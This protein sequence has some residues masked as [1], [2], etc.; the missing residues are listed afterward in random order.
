[1]FRNNKVLR[2]DPIEINDLVLTRSDTFYF[3]EFA[4]YT[5]DLFD[6]LRI[7]S[8]PSLIFY[9]E[10]SVNHVVLDY[11]LSS[12]EDKMFIEAFFANMGVE[13]EFTLTNGS[14]L[15]DT[16]NIEAD[17]SSTLKFKKIT[18]SLIFAEVVSTTDK[19]STVDQYLADFFIGTPQLNK[20]GNLE[21]S[22]RT[23]IQALVS[24][25]P[26]NTAK[27]IL[28]MG[29][30]P[31][32]VIEILC[33]SSV[34][35]NKKFTII[36]AGIINDK[37]VLYLETTSIVSESLIGKAAIINLYQRSNIEISDVNQIAT[38]QTTLG[39]CNDAG[40]N[41]TLPYH[42]QKQ[43]LLRGVPFVWK[44]GSCSDTTTNLTSSVS[45]ATSLLPQQTDVAQEVFDKNIL[46]LKNSV[47]DPQYDQL[48]SFFKKKI[49]DNPDSLFNQNPFSEYFSATDP[50][51][52]VDPFEMFFD[53]NVVRYSVPVVIDSNIQLKA[54][55]AVL[56]GA[57]F[58]TVPGITQQM[59]TVQTDTNIY[60]LLNISFEV[61]IT[62][63]DIKLRT[64]DGYM[65]PDTSISLSKNIL[66][67]IYET[68]ITND[69][70]ERLLFSSNKDKLVPV[71]DFGKLGY[72]Y[73]Q[74]GRYHMF[75]PI[76]ET[77]QPL[78][79]FTNKNK[80]SVYSIQGVYPPALFEAYP[81]I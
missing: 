70:T 73:V 61:V 79:L 80:S 62:D 58:D 34:N 64:I 38:D 2:N 43:C 16:N 72:G 24:L 31:G 21:E 50:Q 29:Y 47:N 14:Y 60:R 6:S 25:N 42:T 33:T 63:T 46:F 4:Q 75:T 66:T 3:L 81:I 39:C 44:S 37:E 26:K 19:E 15:D 48:S 28:C 67:T 56:P 51:A 27:P 10:T 41:I 18:E 45:T 77:V 65:I 12:K 9:T 13:E 22:E 17:L 5:K 55:Q 69:D 59:V 20:S 49:I 74:M 54:T 1:M 76:A 8:K 57:V 11:S 68:S 35:N 23:K 40:A 36:D 53:E 78:Y 71:T 30:Q 7:K 52:I 32:D